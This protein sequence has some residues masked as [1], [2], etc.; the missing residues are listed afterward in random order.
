MR[1]RMV[2]FVLRSGIGAFG[3][4]H[5]GKG[6]RIVS[7]VHLFSEMEKEKATYL[8]F[9]FQNSNY[10]ARV[11]TTFDLCEGKIKPVNRKKLP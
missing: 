1:K 3:H 2:R 11:P 4:D 10:I 5:N 6:Q 8:P 7:F 9:L